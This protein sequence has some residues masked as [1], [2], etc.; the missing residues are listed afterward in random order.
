M[1]DVRSASIPM[2]ATTTT[3][4]SASGT[5][6]TAGIRVV[7]ETGDS[8]QLTLMMNGSVHVIAPEKSLY[9][10]VLT[11]APP[12]GPGLRWLI[13]VATPWHWGIWRIEEWTLR[14]PRN[15]EFIVTVTAHGRRFTLGAPRGL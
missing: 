2:N 7:H 11:H 14:L 1:D 6:T 8:T 12:A 10:A 9:Q 13:A 15:S 5:A 4:G 3:P